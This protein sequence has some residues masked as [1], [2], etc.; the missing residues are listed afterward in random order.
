MGKYDPSR[1]EPKWLARWEKDGLYR[2]DLEEG[3]RPKFYNLM[4]FP[5]PSAEGLHVG[6]VFTYCGSDTYGRFMRM[7]GYKVFEPIGFDA[8]GINTENY[9]LKQGI[10]PAVLTA[11]TVH[12]YRENQMKRLGAMFDWSREVNTSS[13]GY[14]RWTQWVFLQLYRAGLAV[15]KRA[16]V[17]WCPSCLTVL[18]NEQ[19]SSGE[20]ERCGTAVVQKHMTQWFFRITAYAER[21]LRGLE[22]LDWPETSKKLQT[23]WIGKS[24]GAEIAFQVSGAKARLPVFTTR[25]DTLFGATYLVLAPEHPLVFDL[26]SPNRRQQVEEYLEETRRV[27]EFDRVAGS[28]EKT[29][30]FTGAYAI[31]PATGENIPVWV[32][33]YVLVHYGSGAVMGV[34][35]HD[36]RD[37][38]FAVAHQLPIREVIASQPGISECAYTGPGL[39]VNSGPFTGLDSEQGKRAVT[40][41]L[42]EQGLARP[43]VT[44]RLRDWCISR[45][46]YWGPP[47][48]VVYC[49]GCGE[50]P[51]PESHLPVVLPEVE[52]FR[53]LGTGLS[54]LAAVP[55]FVHTT[56]PRC[57]GQARR[58]T[59]V[60]DTFLDSAWYF[61]RYPSAHHHQ[62]PF[63]PGVT[64]RWLPVDMYMG[65]IEHV[66][67]HHLYARF[68]N[69]V[70][71]DLGYVA[72]EE[73]FKRLRLHGL[74]IKDGAKMS[75]S[76]GNVVN[77]DEYIDGYGADVFRAYLL[78]IGP[79][80]EENDFSDRGIEGMA[81]FANRVWNF[82]NGP[83]G[84]EGRGVPMVE[85]HRVIREVTAALES[86]SY[87]TA[88]ARIMELTS[89]GY[90]N[91]S[92]FSAAQRRE[93]ARTLA[94]L[95]SPFMPML[96]EELWET[97]GE[98]YSI[99]DQ[100]WPAYDAR[101]L[102]AQEVTIVVQVDGKVRDRFQAV[103]GLP[104]GEAVALAMSCPKVRA[105]LDGQKPRAHY[106]VPDRLVNLISRPGQAAGTA[107]GPKG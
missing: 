99:H 84:P 13:V 28:S 14:Y 63:E 106:Y 97:L 12:H 21:L 9:A 23:N 22:Y 50:L 88:L 55:E 59:D 80:E 17:N 93:V 62:R 72:H 10:H 105:S 87:H 74:L 100:P 67:M 78:F 6:H 46:R 66:C 53:P 94:L 83:A 36:Q 95:L 2:T 30:I 48:P 25:P 61:L 4:E 82:V 56:C 75:K 101:L 47:I 73:P 89:W 90:R 31:N 92:R 71:Y 64:R 3:G 86:L 1:V 33:A 49:P 85:V 35:G 16:P 96:T 104:E 41:W 18:A 44:Y 34:P 81:R 91:S 52:E 24:E 79:Y 8:F 98:D 103:R 54:P 5:Y 69:M 51:V 58:E 38:E 76:R 57:G 77:P 7:K 43:Q 37:Y 20:C 60:S 19:V 107:G 15:R 70:L 11:A 29:G 102:Q 65:G 40:A 68:I 27:R 26:C 45:Q 39:M 32:A 42:Q